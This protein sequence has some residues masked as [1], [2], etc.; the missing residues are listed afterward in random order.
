MRVR[1]VTLDRQVQ[2]EAHAA[3]IKLRK[4]GIVIHIAIW[5]IALATFADASNLDDLAGGTLVFHDDEDG[6]VQSY[7]GIGNST[8]LPP[9]DGVPTPQLP[10]SGPT[11]YPL[12]PFRVVY[13]QDSP[14]LA[15]TSLIPPEL[16]EATP[17]EKPLV[18]YHSILS[19]EVLHLRLCTLL[20]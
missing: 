7:F 16:D 13:D 3:G 4:S 15:A 17:A 18:Q 11:H 5:V 1:A 12:P 19:G 2:K 10:K 9:Q 8:I 6:I 14:S 20:I